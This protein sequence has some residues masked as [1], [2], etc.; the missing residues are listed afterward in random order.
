MSFMVCSTTVQNCACLQ[1]ICDNQN[2][3]Y[4]PQ[5]AAKLRYT[6]SDVTLHHTSS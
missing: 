3:V 1:F 2:Y 6:G 4:G 5:V